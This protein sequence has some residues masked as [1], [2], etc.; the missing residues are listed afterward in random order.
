MAIVKAPLKTDTAGKCSRWSASALL[1]FLPLEVSQAADVSAG[2]W[3]DVTVTSMLVCTS[4]V[5]PPEGRVVV[6]VSAVAG[7][8]PPSCSSGHRE[9]VVLD[10][11]TAASKLAVALLQQSAVMGSQLVINGTGTCDLD[12]GI[13]TLGIFSTETFTPRPVGARPPTK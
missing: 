8:S 1:L 2:K 11:S 4:K 3:I 9:Q 6:T 12:P 10:V 7:G 13:E 5:C